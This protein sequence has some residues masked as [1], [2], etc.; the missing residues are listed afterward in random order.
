MYKRT[1][2]ILLTILVTLAMAGCF[3]RS[4]P[5]PESDA[6]ESQSAAQPT[7]TPV[8]AVAESAATGDELANFTT[9]EE[10]AAIGSYRMRISMTSTSA[11]GTDNVQIEGEYV[12]EP[13][14]ERLVMNYDQSGETQTMEMLLVDGVRYMQAKGMWMAAPDMVPNLKELTLITPSDMGEIGS[15]LVRIGDETVNGRATTH[16]RGDKN[17]IPVVGTEGDT[18]DA[19]QLEEAQIDLWVDQA[20]NF[21]VKMQL[22]MKGD[23]NDADAEYDMTFEYYDFN[24]DIVLEKPENALSLPGMGQPPAAGEQPAS[25]APASEPQTDLGKLLGFDL[26]LP[27]GSSVSV[28]SANMTQVTTPYTLEEAV[29]LL[30]LK[31]QENGYTAMSQMSPAAGQQMLMYQKGVKIVTINITANDSGSEWQVI[32]GP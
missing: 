10:A 17:T 32:A 23:K 11:R 6:G 18:L 3:S 27:T 5:V 24:A 2:I 16:F 14:A 9:V 1:G 12:K 30:G 22:T 21:L 19:S 4:E 13:P 28:L 26:Q 7:D 8:P 20:A 31:M 15:G 25:D 29:N